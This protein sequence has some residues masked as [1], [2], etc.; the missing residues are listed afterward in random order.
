VFRDLRSCSEDE[1]VAEAA[2]AWA[3]GEGSVIWGKRGSCAMRSGVSLSRDS[4][5]QNAPSS[6]SNERD[7]VSCRSVQSGMSVI[8]PCAYAGSSS[9]WMCGSKVPM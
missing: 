1:V 7:R 5:V 4:S 9:S 2:R 6:T 3:G 8:C